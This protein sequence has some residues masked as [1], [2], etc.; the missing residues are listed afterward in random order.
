MRPWSVAARWPA[1]WERQEGP[2]AAGTAGGRATHPGGGKLCLVFLG[3]LFALRS[4]TR[5]GVGRGTHWGHFWIDR[6]WG[7]EWVG[8]PALWVPGHD[9]WTQSAKLVFTVP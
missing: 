4:Q 1:P 3:R 9:F 6:G 7:Q 2:Q 5:T 8:L